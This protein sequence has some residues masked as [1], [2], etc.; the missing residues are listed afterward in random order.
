MAFIFTLPLRV[1]QASMA[2]IVLVLAAYVSNHWTWG[3]TW[4]PSSVNFLIFCAA[5]TL[6]ALVYLVLAPLRFPGAAHKFAILAVE[7]VTTI[8]W[9]AGWV[10]LASLLG[11][12][13]LG[14]WAVGHTATAACVFAAFEW[15]VVSRLETFLPSNILTIPK[16]VLLRV[17]HHGRDALLA[18]AP[19]EL[20]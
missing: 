3:G 13:G 5:W 8:F 4:S 19:R 12:I 1:T 20:G 17:H 2:F 10:S 15:C 14:R 9:F 18:D 16:V 7:V 11:D 6:L